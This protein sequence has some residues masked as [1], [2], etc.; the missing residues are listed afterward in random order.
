M[1][2]F[3]LQDRIPRDSLYQCPEQFK[4]CPLEVQGSSFADLPPDFTKK[5]EVYHF[6]VT[7]PQTAPD[8]HISHQSFSVCEEQV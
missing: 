4:V 3:I 6:V 5:R 7:L 2:S 8:H 1:V